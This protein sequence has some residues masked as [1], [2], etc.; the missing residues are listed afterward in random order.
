MKHSVWLR[1]RAWHA[2]EHA[3]AVVHTAVCALA[4]EARNFGRASA[5]TWYNHRPEEAGALEDTSE[6]P[7]FDLLFPWDP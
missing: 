6:E 7:G 3:P 5:H 1:K 4:S 2:R